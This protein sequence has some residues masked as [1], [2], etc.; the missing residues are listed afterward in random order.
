MTNKENKN[1]EVKQTVAAQ[2]SPAIRQSVITLRC[3][4]CSFTKKK[5][6]NVDLKNHT[7]THRDNKCS[8]CKIAFN[9][10]GSLKQ[11]MLNEHRD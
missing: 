4:E 5:K 10:E 3:K 6:N 8:I 7:N 11:H 1:S 2:N 9:S